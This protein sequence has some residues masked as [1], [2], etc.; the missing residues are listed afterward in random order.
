MS[1]KLMENLYKKFVGGCALNTI[2][3]PGNY[4]SK[5]IFKKMNT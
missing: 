3:E 5:A 2:T 1:G 4:K